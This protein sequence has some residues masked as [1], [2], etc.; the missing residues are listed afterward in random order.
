M[1]PGH[2]GSIAPTYLLVH[3]LRLSRDCQ[4][5]HINCRPSTLDWCHSDKKLLLMVINPGAGGLSRNVPRNFPSYA[6][7]ISSFITEFMFSGRM[8]HSWEALHS[9]VL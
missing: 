8:F 2:I 4:G 9:I 7:N 1:I 6:L 3:L 5:R